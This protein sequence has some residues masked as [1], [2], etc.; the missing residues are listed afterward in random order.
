[1][2][3]LL[4]PNARR[5]E[6]RP[7]KPG[8][9]V[10]DRAPRAAT[11]STS[12]RR[13]ER[14]SALL[15]VLWLSLALVAIVFALSRTVRTE[16]DRAALSVD[17]A[18]AYFLAQ[19]GL[20]AAMKRMAEPSNPGSPEAAGFRPGQRFMRFG[21]PSGWVDVEIIAENG[22]LGLMQATPEALA[23]LLSVCGLDPAQA[24]ATAAA[25]VEFRSRARGGAGN[26]LPS[27]SFSASPASI[28]ELEELLTAPG[29]TPDVLYGSYRRGPQGRLV[30]FGGLYRQLSLKG[31]GALS[32]DYASVELLQAAGLPPELIA[33]IEQIRAQRPLQTADPG[34]QNLSAQG[35]DIRL[36]LGGA[37]EA[38]TLRAT[39]RLRNGR[40]T[41]SVAAL[42]ELDTVP[43]PFRVEAVRWY[44]N[45]Y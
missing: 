33:T 36:S 25:I 45:A 32:A 28:S 14:G 24:V 34:M 40:A 39:A 37:A 29:V 44:D 22:K 23:R 42:V 15:A 13:E 31:S 3:R 43:G 5:R 20:E 10:A 16:F 21:F 6:A 35:Q 4:T 38:Y 7:K 30:R 26:P 18:R 11:R 8:W 2:S 19:G 1:M 27:S 41:R 9:K 17:T 12:R